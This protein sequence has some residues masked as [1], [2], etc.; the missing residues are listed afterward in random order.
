MNSKS[1]KSGILKF[2]KYNEKAKGKRKHTLKNNNA[3]NTFRINNKGYLI[4][5]Q[6]NLSRYPQKRKG[7]QNMVPLLLEVKRNNV[8]AGR[9][10]V[11]MF[12]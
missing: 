10:Y 11:G 2:L 1:H 12:R 5:D 8:R 3:R 9:N 4:T 7:L 6:K